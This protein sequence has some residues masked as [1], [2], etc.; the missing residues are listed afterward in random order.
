[1]AKRIYHFI[2]VSNKNIM[3]ITAACGSDRKKTVPKVASGGAFVSLLLMVGQAYS[4]KKPK[5]EFKK[6]CFFQSVDW[7]AVDD[8]GQKRSMSG[9]AGENL[10]VTLRVIHHVFLAL[11]TYENVGRLRLSTFSTRTQG[12]VL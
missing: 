1:M 6:I 7:F 11:S 3:P 12:N 9:K 4:L 10:W 5:K 8:C 2:A